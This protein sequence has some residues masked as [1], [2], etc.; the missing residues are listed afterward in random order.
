M[1]ELVRKLTGFY[2]LDVDM[3]EYPSLLMYIWLGWDI[4]EHV[5]GAYGEDCRTSYGHVN[6]ELT[7]FTTVLLADARAECFQETSQ[8]GGDPQSLTTMYS[9]LACKHLGTS[10]QVGHVGGWGWGGLPLFN[11]KFLSLSFMTHAYVYIGVGP[12]T[13][14]P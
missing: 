11:I 2:N 8:T 10:F 7:S 6:G 3:K 14:P 13:L 1:H 12:P 4:R 5:D 9:F